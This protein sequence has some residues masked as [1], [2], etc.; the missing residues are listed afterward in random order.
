MTINYNHKIFRAVS[1]TPG[2]EVDAETRFYYYQRDQILW[3]T[4]QGPQILFGTIT[5]VVAED[6]ALDFA[7]QHINADLQIKTGRCQS[8]PEITVDGKIRLQEKWQWTDGSHGSGESI[9]EEI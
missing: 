3:A 7:Y 9:I 1:N 8:T 4:Y 5:G 2:G 6:G